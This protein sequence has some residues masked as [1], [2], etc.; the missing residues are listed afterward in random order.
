MII[1]HWDVYVEEIEEIEKIAQRSEDKGSENNFEAGLDESRSTG[2]QSPVDW[3]IDDGV[4]KYSPVNRPV[5]RDKRAIDRRPTDWKWLLSVGAGQ[6]T[7]RPT[8]EFCCPFWIRTPF[9]FWS[10]IQSGF[11]KTLGLCGYK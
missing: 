9:L 3:A 8:N 1:K 5:D 11:T 2:G 10:R 7:G 4:H 6:P